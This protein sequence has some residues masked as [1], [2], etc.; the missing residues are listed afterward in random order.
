MKRTA[1]GAFMVGRAGSR[2]LGVLR[3]RKCVNEGDQRLK[4]GSKFPRFF[5]AACKAGR[6]I[7]I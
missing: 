4:T 1:V 7:L 5:P 3:A 6:L 2:L